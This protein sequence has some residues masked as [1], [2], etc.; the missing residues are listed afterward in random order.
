MQ[1]GRRAYHR[2]DDSTNVY[3]IAL[4]SSA[5][6]RTKRGDWM[7]SVLLIDKDADGVV[8]VCKRTAQQEDHWH[9]S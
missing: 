6:Y 3:A 7:V 8:A 1:S 4:S 2:F 5:P 9:F